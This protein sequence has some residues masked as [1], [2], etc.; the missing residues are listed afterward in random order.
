VTLDTILFTTGSAA[1]TAIAT[2]SPMVYDF[3]GS[4]ILP[5]GGYATIWSNFIIPASSMLSTFA[6]EE[7]STTI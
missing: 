1:T 2:I 3:E 5:P 6:W 7:V 4:I